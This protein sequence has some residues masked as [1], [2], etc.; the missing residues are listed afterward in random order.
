MYDNVFN[1]CELLLRILKKSRGT[2]DRGGGRGDREIEV[3]E[4][5][6]KWCYFGK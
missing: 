4:D 2:K 6:G 5:F 1:I 3:G